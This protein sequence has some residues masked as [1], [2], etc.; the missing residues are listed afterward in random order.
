M[1]IFANSKISDVVSSTIESRRRYNA[2]NLT[3][4]NAVFRELAMNGN[5]D[6]FSGG[7]YIME[8]LMFD[9]GTGG[10][11]AQSYSGAEI[12]NISPVQTMSAAAY[13]IAQYASAL[14]ISGLEEI[15]NAGKER[16][17]DLL[18]SRIKICEATLKNKISSDIFKDGTGNNFKDIL[19]IRAL[20]PYPATASSAGGATPVVNYIN[21][22]IY[23]GIDRSKFGFWQS[24]AMTISGSGTGAG[25][26][27]GVGAVNTANQTG[28]L[29]A[30]NLLSLRLVRDMD[31][32]NLIVA[33][34]YMYST[35]MNSMQT[36]QRITEAKVGESGFQSLVYNG[37]GSEC[38]VILG[39]GMSF[40][41]DAAKS[42]GGPYGQENSYT[43][44]FLN[45]KYLH[46]RPHTARNFKLLG[47][48]FSIAQD[49]MVNMMVWAGQL[50]CSGAAFQGILYAP[51]GTY[52]APTLLNAA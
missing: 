17:I 44:Y 34:E 6:T 41:Q 4:N 27:S 10:S 43:M 46:L 11:N 33:G 21:T 31:R 2:D 49:A 18:S 38:K 13:P 25:A 12:I 8:N 5:I 16:I 26:L 48:K 42:Q 29:N 20:L 9:G 36:I 22:G 32:P 51:P 52:A 7:T 19:G 28:I 50:T 30:M 14:T 3:Y 45:T 39:G 37:A 24:P 35:F 23:G 47:E 15:Q 40:A 1:S